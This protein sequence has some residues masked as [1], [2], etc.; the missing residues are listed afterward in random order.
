MTLLELIKDGLIDEDKKIVLELDFEKSDDEIISD[1]IQ[2]GFLN[3]EYTDKND[4]K[5]C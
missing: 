1:I 4:K 3:I 5:I 2:A